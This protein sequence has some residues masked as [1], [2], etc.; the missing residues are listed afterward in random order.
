M[1]HSTPLFLS[2][3]LVLTSFLRFPFPRAFITRPSGGT[4][5]SLFGRGRFQLVN[6]CLRE[7]LHRKRIDLA[8]PHLCSSK[9][10]LVARG[11]QGHIQGVT[12][13]INR[14]NGCFPYDFHNPPKIALAGVIETK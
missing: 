1:I 4:P 8:I 2:E 10:R 11:K 12:S 9:T 14:P 6:G 7:A 13:C 5:A 3:Y